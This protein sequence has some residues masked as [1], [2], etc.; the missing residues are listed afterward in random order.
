MILFKIDA[1]QIGF[2]IICSGRYTCWLDFCG[3]KQV[4]IRLHV[5]VENTFI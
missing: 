3:Q 2:D 1:I 4:G 5:K